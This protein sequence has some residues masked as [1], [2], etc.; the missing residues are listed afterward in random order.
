MAACHTALLAQQFATLGDIE[1]FKLTFDAWK[2][3]GEAGEYTNAL[4]G[5][6]SAYATPKVGTEQYQ[7]RHVHLV[8]LRDP[9]QLKAWNRAH[10]RQSRKTSDRVLVYASDSRDKHLLIYILDEP[11]AH[12]IAQMLSSEDK[13]LMH[14]FAAIAEAFLNDGSIVA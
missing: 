12:S 14:R 2:L 9:Q 10:Q 5:K 7:L 6:D 4:F 3:E 13:L 1:T 11:S 8:P